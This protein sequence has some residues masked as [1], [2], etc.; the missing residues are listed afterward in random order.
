MKSYRESVKR[1]QTEG[2]VRIMHDDDEGKDKH[3]KTD[4]FE[5]ENGNYSLVLVVSK[6]S[7]SEASICCTFNIARGLTSSLFIENMTY[8]KTP[9]AFFSRLLK[10]KL[11]CL[12]L[13]CFIA[14]IWTSEIMLCVK[15]N[16]ELC[17]SKCFQCT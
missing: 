8:Q 14:T 5:N 3:N 10:A 13:S 2:I 7:Q 4:F 16:V 17:K 15:H 1:E 11:L 6:M 9:I 12:N